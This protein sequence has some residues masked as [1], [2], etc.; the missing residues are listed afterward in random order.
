MVIKMAKCRT[1]PEKEWHNAIKLSDDK[2]KHTGDSEELAH[3]IK[4][5]ERG[6]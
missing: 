1:A 4:V 5:L 2:G 6:M 3:C